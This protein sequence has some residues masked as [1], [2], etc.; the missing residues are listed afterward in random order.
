MS[1]G[2]NRS[3][4]VYVSTGYNKYVAGYHSN[5]FPFWEGPLPLHLFVFGFFPVSFLLLEGFFDL[6]LTIEGKA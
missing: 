4:G 1:D 6:T 2:F 5:E 3:T